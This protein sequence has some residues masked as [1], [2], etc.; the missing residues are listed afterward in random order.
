MSAPPVLVI[1]TNW[2]LD[3]WV[4]DD[5]RGLALRG[6][7]EQGQVRW[8]ACPAMRVE[9]ERVLGYPAVARRLLA[10]DRS[11]DSVLSEF[12]RRVEWAEPAPLAPFRCADPDD[13][14]FIDLAVEWRATLLSKDGAVLALRRRLAPLG[15]A[16]QQSWP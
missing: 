10:N 7:L 1:D 3:L 8:L 9:F 2:L 4:F 16:I 15:V 14:V 11:P 5:P 12:D 13:Q 6:A